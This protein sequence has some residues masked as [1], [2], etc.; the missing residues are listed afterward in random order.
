[1]KVT[2]HKSFYD[3]A[4]EEAWLEQ[5]SQKGLA[6]CE[7]TLCRYVFETSQPGEY[8]YRM[9]LLKRPA[10][11]DHS[12]GVVRGLEDQGVECVGTNGC[13]FYFRRKAADGPIELPG[14]VDR[15]IDHLRRLAALWNI[16]GYLMLA[17]A[18]FALA[19]SV[20]SAICTPN[21][22]MDYW[23]GFLVAVCCVVAGVLF[24][25]LSIPIRRRIK[26]MAR[27]EG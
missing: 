5:M 9:A 18:A 27:A 7:Y 11:S 21:G 24:L 13:W 6:L 14:G 1:M 20:V 25:R 10:A 26:H 3:Y 19:F 12:L 8:T 4:R 22:L 15:K 2:L 23:Y 16:L 17:L